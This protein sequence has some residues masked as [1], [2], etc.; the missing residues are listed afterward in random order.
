MTF[1]NGDKCM[2]IIIKVQ[3]RSYVDIK[4]LAHLSS[5]DHVY[6][7]RH[8]ELILISSRQHGHGI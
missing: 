5:V 2:I 4:K 6:G 3:M 7:S 8:D 1:L